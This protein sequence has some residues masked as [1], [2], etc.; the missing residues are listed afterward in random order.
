MNL[1]MQ[2]PDI[3]YPCEWEY[4]II[5]EDEELIKKLVFDTMPR[6]YSLKISKHSKNKRFVSV[7]VCVITHSEEERNDIFQ[8]FAKSKCV[9]MVI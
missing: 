3:T 9:K 4:R 6:E 8:T 1:D 5:G 2:K 7:H